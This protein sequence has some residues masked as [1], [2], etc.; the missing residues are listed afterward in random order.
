MYRCRNTLRDYLEIV[1]SLGLCFSTLLTVLIS[2]L[3]GSC[4]TNPQAYPWVEILKSML[5]TCTSSHMF[6]GLLTLKLT[7]EVVIWLCNKR[8]LNHVL[9]NYCVL[10]SQ[11]LSIHDTCPREFSLK[12]VLSS[13][14][15][16]REGGKENTTH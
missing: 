15:Q 11:D 7:I 2:N 12:M 8:A 1:M 14:L 13:V 16:L 5:P 4:G 6:A 9:E 3:E 10:E